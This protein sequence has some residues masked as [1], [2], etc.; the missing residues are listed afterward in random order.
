MSVG[1]EADATVLAL[2]FNL[3]IV[4]EALVHKLGAIGGA[5][6]FGLPTVLPNGHVII[7]VSS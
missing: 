4:M 2:F 7:K 5:F 1:C 6:S 3:L